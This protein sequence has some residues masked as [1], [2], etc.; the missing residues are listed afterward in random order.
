MAGAPFRLTEMGVVGGNFG[1]VTS[2]EYRLHAVADIFGDPT[3][4]PHEG[5]VLRRYQEWI[6]EAPKALGAILGIT[7]GLSL[8]FL[9]EQWQGQPVIVVLT[10]W[11]GP[12]SENDHA[13][14]RDNYRQNY[15]RLARIKARFDSTNLFRLNQNIEPL[16]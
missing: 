12:A 10:C 8:P 13:R 4:I 9:P 5:D 1:V 11:S 15:A 6:A 2:F 7:L 3:F 16:P 14:V